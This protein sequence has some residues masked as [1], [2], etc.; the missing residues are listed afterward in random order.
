MLSVRMRLELGT[1]PTLVEQRSYVLTLTVK[2]GLRLQRKHFRLTH[3]PVPG[4]H[5]L[6]SRG[7]LCRLRRLLWRLWCRSPLPSIHD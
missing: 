2:D 5:R 7:L 3:L 1:I 4:W 6:R